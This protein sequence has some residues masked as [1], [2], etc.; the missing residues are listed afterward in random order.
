M[1]HISTNSYVEL[2]GHAITR[3]YWNPSCFDGLLRLQSHTRF[4]RGN[5]PEHGRAIRAVADLRPSSPSQTC[6]MWIPPVAIRSHCSIEHRE[7][8]LTNRAHWLRHAL[9]ENRIL[10]VKGQIDIHMVKPPGVSNAIRPLYSALRNHFR[11]V[12]LYEADLRAIDAPI[13]NLHFHPATGQPVREA[14]S[15][16]QWSMS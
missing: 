16:A 14:S 7:G 13:T 12:S 9:T 1:S 11:L 4:G 2:C 3:D 15:L 5:G 10:V 6:L 8:N